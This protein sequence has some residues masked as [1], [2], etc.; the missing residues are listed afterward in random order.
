MKSYILTLANLHFKKNE[1][2]WTSEPIDL[3]DNSSYINYS[4]LKSRYGLNTIGDRN[5][6]W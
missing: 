3:Y 1:K 6:R 4:T 5:V 2:V